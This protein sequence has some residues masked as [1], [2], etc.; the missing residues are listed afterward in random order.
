M[1]YFCFLLLL[2]SSSYLTAATYNWVGGNSDWEDPANWSPNGNPGNDDEVVIN[3]GTVHLHSAASV[4][5]IYIAPAGTLD[6]EKPGSLTVKLGHTDFV[7]V[8]GNLFNGGYFAVLGDPDG[9]ADYAMENSG[10]FVNN[11]IAEIL[12]VS[13]NGVYCGSTST[14]INNG[15]FLVQ[16]VP[17]IRAVF[18]EGMAVNKGKM[19]LQGFSHSGWRMAGTLY[20]SGHILIEGNRNGINNNGVV[21]NYGTITIDCD[22]VYTYFS[23][24]GG[25][26]NNYQEGE[27]FC[28]GAAVHVD[29]YCS[30]FNYGSLKAFDSPTVGLRNYGT[31]TNFPSGQIEIEGFQEE[32]LLNRLSGLFKNRGDLTIHNAAG[33]IVGLQNEATFRNLAQGM[34]N[35]DATGS[36]GVRNLDGI[37][38]N[39]GRLYLSGIN[40]DGVVNEGGSIFRNWNG[41][42]LD[43]QAV[44]G[45]SVDNYQEANF[46]NSDATLSC[47]E[48]GVRSIYNR[49]SFHNRRCGEVHAPEQVVNRSGAD[50]TNDAWLFTS[51]PGQHYNQAGGNMVNNGVIE[52][53]HGAFDGVQLTNNGV[54]VGPVA[55]PAYVGQPVPGILGL[56]SFSSATVV[57]WWVDDQGTGSAG[58]YD[59]VNNTFTPNG[60]AANTTMLYV[61]VE[62][63]LDKDCRAKMIAINFEQGI[64]HYHAMMQ[65][66][67]GAAVPAAYSVQVYPNPC[68]GYCQVEIELEQPGY[69]TLALYHANGQL[70]WQQAVYVDAPTTFPV[71]AACLATGTYWL[72]WQSD[73]G[74]T[75]TKAVVV[76]P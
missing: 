38:L 36:T 8:D 67:S 26:F 32:G 50:F 23:M 16:S 70:V 15:D 73:Q 12:S 1:R 24:Q 56:G 35:I 21:D 65:D 9:T 48:G 68:P 39:K 18:T 27:L 42:L 57:G 5:R 20:N 13:D 4:R 75:L 40:G 72:R 66:D 58:S 60:Y 62:L 19:R 10:D 41:G 30:F 76:T 6:I 43:I 63:N 47:A 46:D 34:L 45:V 55:D 51:Y 61:E 29:I 31:F 37:I 25:V 17:G 44:T 22:A 59:S 33:A 49:R 14:F 7:D 53:L 11:G 3:S 64:R 71:G 52:D 54:I 2:C 28:S 69:G 74:E